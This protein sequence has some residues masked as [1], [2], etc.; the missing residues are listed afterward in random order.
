MLKKITSYT[1]LLVGLILLNS[2]KKEY[3]S[4]QSIDDTKIKDYISSNNITD[5]IEDPDKT[6]ISPMQ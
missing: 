2:C 6:I 1:F 4:I 5:A 3:E